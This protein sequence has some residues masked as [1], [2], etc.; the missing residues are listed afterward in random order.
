M[1]ALLG[2]TSTVALAGC[3]GGGDGNGGTTDGG[4]PTPSSTVPEQYVRATAQN[5]NQR[6]PDALS[7]KSAV[8]YQKTPKDGQQCSGC[9]YYIPDKNGDGMGACAIVEGEIEPEGWC[10]SYSAYETTEPMQAVAVP[11]DARCAVC[12]MKAAKYPDWNAQA[13]HEDDTREFF[14]SPGCATTYYA[15]PETFAATAS[16]VAG[17]WVTGYESG[18]FIDGTAA[19]YALETDRDR[20]DD[21]MMVNPVP[22]RNRTDAVAYVDEVD[23]LNEDDIVS[24]SAFDRGLAKEYRA[25][26][27]DEA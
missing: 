13:V 16:P 1:L 25:R 21:P 24:L 10:L 22:F 6:N 20:L 23:Y 4:T 7:S 17:F 26:Y 8:N 5:G 27:L 2:T 11:D 19:S 12:H 14:C 15:V 3:G 18:D 9:A